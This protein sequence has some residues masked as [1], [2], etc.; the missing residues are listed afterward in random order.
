MR[1]YHVRNNIK[2]A[3]GT[4]PAVKYR[5]RQRTK[6]FGGHPERME[7]MLLAARAYNMKIEN[8]RGR[9]RPRI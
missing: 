9:G 3:V 2:G 8:S 1:R 6:W 5:E 7:T 4:V